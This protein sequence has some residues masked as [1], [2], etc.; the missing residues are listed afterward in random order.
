MQLGLLPPTALSDSD[1][2]H[3]AFLHSLPEREAQAILDMT[4]ALATQVNKRQTTTPSIS[5]LKQ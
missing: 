2:K 4:E 1:A 3:L 5:P